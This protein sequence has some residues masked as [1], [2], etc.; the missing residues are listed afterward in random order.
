MFK[1]LKYNF[2]N[3]FWYYKVRNVDIPDFK[4]CADIRLS[5]TNVMLNS[6]GLMVSDD[7]IPWYVYLS[8]IQKKSIGMAAQYGYKASLLIKDK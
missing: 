2:L 8:N 4:K 6:V 3:F 1:F 5:I 7:S